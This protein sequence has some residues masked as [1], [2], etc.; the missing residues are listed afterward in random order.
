MRAGARQFNSSSVTDYIRALLL[1]APR[2]GPDGVR[3]AIDGLVHILRSVGDGGSRIAFPYAYGPVLD[4]IEVS[5]E[6]SGIEVPEAEIRDRCGVVEDA[7]VVAWEA[8]IANPVLLADFSL[9]PKQHP[10]PTLVHNWAF[11]TR[12]CMARW[13][14]G[15]RLAELLAQAATIPALS[16]RMNSG[17][18]SASD[19]DQ[20]AEGELQNLQTGSAEN[21]YAAIGRRLHIAQDAP[22]DLRISLLR[23]L[24]EKCLEFGPNELD[25]AV[26]VLATPHRGEIKDQL[27]RCRLYKKGSARLEAR[28]Q[29]Q[30][31]Y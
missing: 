10:N 28:F 15:V 20:L 11:A 16:S 29:S 12:R 26:F 9:P 27:Y 14:D 31:V 8:I 24:M 6:L 2:V 23:V 22:Q 19:L 17:V 18:L 30:S 5:G 21:F 13:G 3:D 25:V 1:A 7:L 4:L